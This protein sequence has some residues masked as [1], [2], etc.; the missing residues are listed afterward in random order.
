MMPAYDKDVF[1]PGKSTAYD[2]EVF[3]VTKRKIDEKP[4]PVT[5][6]SGTLRFA[7]PMGTLDTRIPLPEML[8]KALAQYGSGVADWGLGFNQRTGKATRDDK[9]EKDRLDAEL[10]KGIVGGVLNIA[11]K[12]APTMA[13]PGGPMASGIAAGGLSGFFE[14]V[15]KDGSVASNTGVGMALGGTLP[16]LFGAASKI[17]RP[18]AATLDLAR[19]AQSAGIPI[20]PADMTSNRLVKGLRSVTDD[21]PLVGAPGYAHRNAQQTAFNQAVGRE[22]GESA[23]SLTPDVMDAAAKRMGGEFDRLWGRNNLVVDPK[24]IKNMDALRAAALDLP[25]EEAKRTIG[26]IDD[27]MSRQSIDTSGNFVVSG[28]VANKFQQWLRTKSTGQSLFS[29]DAANLRKQIISSFNRSISPQDAEAL[30]KARSQW[31][32]F[33]TVAPL[34]NKG[35]A[36]VAGRVSGDVPAALLSGAVNQ[37]YQTL[38]RQTAQPAIAD[39]AKIGGRFLVDRTPMTGGSPRAM[40]QNMGVA[41]LGGGGIG[42]GLW[43]DPLATLAGT[44]VGLGTNALLNSGAVGRAMTDTTNRGLLGAPSMTKAAKEA[45]R[46]VLERSPIGL[47]GE[48]PPIELAF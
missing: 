13:V 26:A 48:A 16:A 36:G 39:L 37:S 32:V 45:L 33:S 46:K 29:D 14:P 20:A 44:G 5:D 35:E 11:G 1:G 8:N 2:P 47:L 28:D 40:L 9:T 41:G 30:T 21:L 18:D 7:T 24:L 23:G 3:P 27:F 15:G 38:S 31:K 4:V 34:M 17:V 43:F 19:K 6:F 10:T 25:K 22:M 12:V 42:A